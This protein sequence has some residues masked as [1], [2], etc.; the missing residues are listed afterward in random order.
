RPRLRRFPWRKAGVA[1]ASSSIECFSLRRFPRRTVHAA[2]S[3]PSANGDRA[4]D[5]VCFTASKATS[6]NR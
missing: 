4:R 2:A 6:Y 5:I 3:S 1:L